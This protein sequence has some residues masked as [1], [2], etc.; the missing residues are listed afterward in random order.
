MT[1]NPTLLSRALRLGLCAPCCTLVSLA[2][3]ADDAEDLAKKLS[4]PVAALISVPFQYNYDHRFGSTE[5]GHKSY[6]NFQ[7]VVPISIDPEWNV[8]S[9]TILPITLNQSLPPGDSVSGLGDIVQSLFFSPKRPTA[10]GLIWGAGPVFLLP[11]GTDSQLSARKWGIGPTA[12]LL[13]QAGP[14]TYGIL[15]N[16]IWSVAGSSSRPGVSSTFLQPFV[17][18]TTK[19]AWTFGINTESTYDWKNKAVVG[20]DQPDGQQARQVRQ[21]ADQPRRGPEV[22]GRQ[23]GQRPARLRRQADR[24]LP[25][26]EVGGRPDPDRGGRPQGRPPADRSASGQYGG[27]TTMYCGPCDWYQVVPH[28]W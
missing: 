5:Q 18:H 9:R 11:S 20:A 23:P 25:L 8:I 14:F 4:N 13:K 3:Q 12:V 26:S 7:P 19:D 16:H 27:L 6:I 28:C 24:D 15:A 10:A 2:C 17:S 22:L 21:S 1:L